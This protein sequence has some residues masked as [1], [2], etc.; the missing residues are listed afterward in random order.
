MDAKVLTKQYLLGDAKL[1]QVATV[2]GDQPWICTVFF[3]ADD[4]LNVYWLSLPTRRHSREIT[5]QQKAAAAI[6]VKHDKPV[7]GIQIEGDAEEVTDAGVITDVMEKYTAKYDAGRDFYDNF[8]AGKNQHRLYRIRPRM[9]VLFDEVNFPENGR[10]EW[11][12]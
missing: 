2:G 3:V 6:A 5:V 11:Q 10:Q 4:D 9:F 12:H 8:L 1:M 7:T